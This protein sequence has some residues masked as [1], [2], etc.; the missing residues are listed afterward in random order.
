MVGASKV[1]NTDFIWL[2]SNL[3]RLTFDITA[4][5]KTIHNSFFQSLIWIIELDY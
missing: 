4:V 5:I 2:N 1:E 3:N